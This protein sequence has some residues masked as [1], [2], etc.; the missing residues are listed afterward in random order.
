MPLNGKSFKY[1]A[2]AFS[3]ILYWLVCRNSRKCNTPLKKINHGW[4]KAKKRSMKDPTTIIIM[5]LRN[6]YIYV[7]FL[8][9]NLYVSLYKINTTLGWWLVRILHKN[10]AYQH[11][12]CVSSRNLE[13]EKMW[14]S[15]IFLPNILLK[16]LLYKINFLQLKPEFLNNRSRASSAASNS[17]GLRF[18]R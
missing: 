4:L 18:W 1:E 7:G 10:D 14:L 13:T 16:I 3:Y 5:V 17:A 12:Y 2:Q 9:R 11:Q 6:S 8:L 15:T